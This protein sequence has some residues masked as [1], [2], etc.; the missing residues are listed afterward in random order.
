M[1]RCSSGLETRSLNLLLLCGVHASQGKGAHDSRMVKPKGMS[2]LMRRRAWLLV[3]MTAKVEAPP[4][5]S[6]L[7]PAMAGGGGA[8]V[9]PE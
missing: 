4:S 9:E 5:L 3:V 6:M 7:P 2:V 1:W 8:A